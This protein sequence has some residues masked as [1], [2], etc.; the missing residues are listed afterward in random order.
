ML[1]LDEVTNHLDPEHQIAAMSLVRSLGVTVLAAL[2]SLDLAAQ[3]ATSVVVLHKGRIV[4]AGKP[5][6]V[7]M[8]ETFRTVFKVDGSLVADP[9]TETSRA[10]LRALD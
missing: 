8:P 7:L 9:V 5:A 3:Y 6:E 2:R 10:L 4:V 1:V